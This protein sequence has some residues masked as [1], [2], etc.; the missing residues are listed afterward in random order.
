MEETLI[1]WKYGMEVMGHQYPT[2]YKKSIFLFT[3]F[4]LDFL[5]FF[6]KFFFSPFHL[7]AFWKKNWCFLS[8]FLCLIFLLYVWKYN[9]I[10]KHLINRTLHIIIYS[11]LKG[12]CLFQ[13]DKVFNKNTLKKTKVIVIGCCLIFGFEIFFSLIFYFKNKNICKKV[14]FEYNNIDLVYVDLN[15]HSH[16]I[17][18][19]VKWCFYTRRFIGDGVH[20]YVY[21]FFFF[22]FVFFFFFFS[23]FFIF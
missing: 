19:V 9:Q 5:F 4:R 15:V 14:H 8:I 12:S 20:V 16:D 22:W 7:S 13:C 21:V 2:S 1:P 18:N 3:K 11:K 17:L 23:Y 6:F 10:D